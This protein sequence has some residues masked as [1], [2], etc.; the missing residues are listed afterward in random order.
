MAT[1]KIVFMKKNYLDLDY[2]KIVESVKNT[3]KM[4]GVNNIMKYIVILL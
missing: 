4:N 2:K 3:V 1:E